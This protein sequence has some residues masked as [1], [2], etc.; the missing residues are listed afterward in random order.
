MDENLALRLLQRIPKQITISVDCSQFARP[1]KFK[2]LTSKYG[3][4]CQLIKEICEEHKVC[5]KESLVLFQDEAMVLDLEVLK[6]GD[7]C[8]LSPMPTVIG[9]FVGQAKT[10][11]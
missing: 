4:I 8:N 3:H 6:D 2:V 11:D 9:D 5:S 10:F 1:V 7:Y